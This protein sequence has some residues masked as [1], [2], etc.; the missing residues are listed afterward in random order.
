MLRFLSTYK[1]FSH[2]IAP[3]LAKKLKKFE[4]K[5]DVIKWHHHIWQHQKNFQTKGIDNTK[6]CWKFGVHY[7]SN[8]RVIQKPF[9]EFSAW[10][11]G[12]F[13]GWSWKK[14]DNLEW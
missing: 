6:I 5:H 14:V 10:H 4:M 8:V 3:K 13:Y 12:N 7:F 2:N 9:F 11:N 1:N